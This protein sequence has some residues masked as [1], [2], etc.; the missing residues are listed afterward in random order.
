MYGK[1]DKN[2]KKHPM[3]LGLMNACHYVVLPIMVAMAV[4]EFWLALDLSQQYL[5][6]PFQVIVIWYM[7]GSIIQNT[8]R[9]MQKSNIMRRLL[10][11]NVFLYVVPK[12]THQQRSMRRVI[13]KQNV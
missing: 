6:V 7:Y 10:I 5:T 13:I 8:F 1:K 4:C 3:Y 2:D 12:E 9:I 11:S